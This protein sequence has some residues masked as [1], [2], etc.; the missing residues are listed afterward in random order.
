[1]RGIHGSTSYFLG[2]CGTGTSKSP[3]SGISQSGSLWRCHKS[4]MNCANSVSDP[5]R[6]RVSHRG[7][8]L[9]NSDPG[10]GPV[11][12]TAM[13]RR[14]RYGSHKTFTRKSRARLEVQPLEDRT[15]P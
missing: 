8:V 12:G 7:R 1:M 9:V 4:F 2:P 11:E 6:L 5:R 14:V 3:T 13:P 15:V 10:R